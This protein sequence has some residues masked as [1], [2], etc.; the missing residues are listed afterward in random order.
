MYD[1]NTTTIIPLLHV[2]NVGVA[3]CILYHSP[4]NRR[5]DCDLA[6]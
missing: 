3:G 6:D 5:V 2:T 1:A 4:V